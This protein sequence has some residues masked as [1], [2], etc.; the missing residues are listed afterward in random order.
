MT[1]EHL[2]S[3]VLSRAVVLPFQAKLRT[4]PATGHLSL[5]SDKFQGWLVS[6]AGG[7]LTSKQFSCFGLRFL[8]SFLVIDI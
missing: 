2:T 3:S 4:H 5:T 6:A 1:I 8:C 7:L